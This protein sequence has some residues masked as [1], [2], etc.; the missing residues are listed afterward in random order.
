MHYSRSGTAFS[1]DWA[2][3]GRG[4]GRNRGRTAGAIGM[5]RDRKRTGERDR[6]RAG[7]GDLAVGAGA[8]QTT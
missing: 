8:R 2:Q 1:H 6:R 7:E 4:R 5:R 3:S